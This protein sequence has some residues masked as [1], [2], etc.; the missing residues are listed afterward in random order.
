MDTRARGFSDAELSPDALQAGRMDGDAARRLQA[1]GYVGAR[2][3]TAPRTRVDPKDRRALARGLALVASGEVQGEALEKTLA[4]ILE[5][6]AGNP[7]AHLRIGYV[8]LGRG[9]VREAEAHFQ[10]ASRGAPQNADVWLGLASC[11]GARGDLRGADEALRRAENCEPGSPIVA[12]D[13]GVLLSKT[14]RHAQAIALLSQ[15][16]TSDPEFDEA[17]FNLALAYARAGQR[18]AALNEAEVLIRRL[19]AGAAQRGEVE[20]L[21]AELKKD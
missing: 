19:P 11:A 1:L 16:V 9:R 13:R 10:A 17:R 7:Q 5:Q 3:M 12:A 8:L 14:G 20:R 18:E 4:S 21:R 6:D 2:R 15:V